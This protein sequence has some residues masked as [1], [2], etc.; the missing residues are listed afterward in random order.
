MAA[1]SLL[2]FRVRIDH[3][4]NKSSIIVQLRSLVM[5]KLLSKVKKRLVLQIRMWPKRKLHFKRSCYQ[6]PINFTLYLDAIQHFCVTLMAVWEFISKT[7]QV[8]LREEISDE[9]AEAQAESWFSSPITC[10][11][12]VFCPLCVCVCNLFPRISVCCFGEEQFWALFSWTFFSP[13]CFTGFYFGLK[14]WIC[15]H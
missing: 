11:L 7:L 10:W 4:N 9:I 13:S 1:A 14:V 3:F 8:L 2:G 5:W 15:L 6:A 12:S